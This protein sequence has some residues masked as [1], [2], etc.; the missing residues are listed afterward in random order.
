ME[1]TQI[2]FVKLLDI[3]DDKKSFSLEYK[4]NILNHVETIHASAQFALAETQSGVL[5]QEIFPHLEGKVIPLLRDATIKYKKPA[6]KKIYA[7]AS[8]SDE[9]LKK[10]QK[11][12]EKKGRGSIEVDV[13][14]KDIDNVVTAVA[15]FV[16]FVT[17]I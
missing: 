12:F 10:F 6:Q 8:V 16:W 3:K 14:V 13:V 11:L 2:P 5:L 1:V 9:N 15:S 17:M 4:E 7:F